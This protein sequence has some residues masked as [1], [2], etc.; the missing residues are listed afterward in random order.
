MDVYLIICCRETTIFTEAKEATT[1]CLFF[2]RKK[3][4]K[5]ILKRPPGEQQLFTDHQLLDGDHRPFPDCGLSSQSCSSNVL[6][7]VGSA[8]CRPGN[9]TFE[10][11]CIDPFSHSPGLP[12]KSQESSNSSGE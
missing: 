8:L 2:K 12:T 3:V 10:P 11:A 4:V 1:V 6:A 9:G 5:V 7:T